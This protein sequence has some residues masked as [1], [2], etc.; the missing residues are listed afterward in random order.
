MTLIEVQIQSGKQDALQ[1]KL[2]QIR[3]SKQHLFPGTI[4][5]YIVGSQTNPG[6]V[7]I[8]LIWRYLARKLRSDL[9]Q[10]T[11]LR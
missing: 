7:I 5:R 8:S 4:A 10:C 1:Q 6:Q 11:L 9:G 3:K 2:E